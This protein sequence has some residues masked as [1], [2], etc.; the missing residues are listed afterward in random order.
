MAFCALRKFVLLFFALL[1]CAVSGCAITRN[2]YCPTELPLEAVPESRSELIPIDHRLLGATI[3]SEHTVS[4]GDVLG[5]YIENVLGNKDELP[6]VAYPSFRT[7]NAPIEP[8]VGL[9]IKVETDGTIKLPYVDPIFI[10]GYS[11]PEVREAIRREYVENTNLIQEGRDNIAVS[12][13]TP[14]FFRINVIR[15]DTRYNQPG[16]QQVEQ[17]EIS[18]RWSG[19][20][21]YLEPKEA[22]VLTALLRTGGLPGIDAM[23]EIWVMK[24]IEQSDLQR[25]VIPVIKKLDGEQP[26]MIPKEDTKLIRIPL[27]QRIGEEVPFA[28]Q[29]VVLGDGDVVFL[30]KREGDTF[31]TGGLLPPGRF[32][33]PRDRDIDILEAIALCTGSINGPIAGSS[34]PNFKGGVGGIIPPTDVIIVRRTSDNNQ[35]KIRVSLKKCLDDPSERITIAKG[36]LLILRY[37]PGELAGNMALNLFNLNFTVTRVLGQGTGATLL[38]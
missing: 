33:L 36:D 28:P 21:V 14:R 30:P 18:R 17:F 35:I 32:P 9:P 10:D 26:M 22:S 29:D 3:P 24:G 16:L 31:M 2:T 37:R 34:S 6:Q 13:I 4:A 27:H 20:T 5:I 8:F 1:L 25:T 15:Q 12:L 38:E 11:L 7:K 23:N 19:T